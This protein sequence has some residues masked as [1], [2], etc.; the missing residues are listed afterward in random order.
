MNIKR[1][2]EIWSKN[3]FSRTLTF[4]Q[5]PTW[6]MLEHFFNLITL[7]FSFQWKGIFSVSLIYSQTTIDR[8]STN[9]QQFSLNSLNCSWF[10]NRIE[11]LFVVGK[12]WIS[13]WE[14]IRG[15]QKTFFFQST[16]IPSHTIDLFIH[17]SNIY[18]ISSTSHS[19]Q[20]TIHIDV[21]DNTHLY[22]CISKEES[23]RTQ[24][25]TK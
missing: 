11:L 19:I 17:L 12:G 24:H 9:A 6:N 18:P 23:N 8:Q 13:G 15:I 10:G 20:S 5:F 25:I 7:F 2:A 3:L 14:W 1:K 21:Y 22:W 4:N 16:N